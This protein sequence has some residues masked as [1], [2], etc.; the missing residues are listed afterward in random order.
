MPD[1]A[2]DRSDLDELADLLVSL[3]G[4][5]T[6]AAGPGPAAAAGP[7]LLV[8][9]S[10]GAPGTGALLG[11]VG[12]GALDAGEPPRLLT[13]ERESTLGLAPL[14]L[15]R[16]HGEPGLDHVVVVPPG[17]G[18]ALR[19]CAVAASAHLVWIDDHPDAAARAAAHLR[20]LREAAAFGTVGV[21]AAGNR[22]PGLGVPRGAEASWL[23][24][25][26][27]GD[28]LPDAAR[29]FLAELAPARGGL[30][31]ICQLA[32]STRRA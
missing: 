17:D 31:W 10:C 22:P 26:R 4:E 2:R 18:L 8:V 25:W 1:L 30:D 15:G 6:R 27:P 16:P 19:A 12:A 9:T 5:R 14:E 32:R 11:A 20:T 29:T 28:P 23:G 7:R 13:A 21:L 24:R 3:P